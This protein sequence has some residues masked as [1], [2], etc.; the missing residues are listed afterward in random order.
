MDIALIADLNTIST[1][2]TLIESIEAISSMLITVLM[3]V[4]S[5][6]KMCL[7]H[8]FALQ[9]RAMIVSKEKTVLMP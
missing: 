8:L 1:Q 3:T 6:T 5:L 7:K 4:Q 9:H 2:T